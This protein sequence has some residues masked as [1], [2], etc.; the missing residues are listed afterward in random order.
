MRLRVGPTNCSY[1][2][3]MK[4]LALTKPHV[5]VHQKHY[6]DSGCADRDVKFSG[7]IVNVPPTSNYLPQLP[8]EVSARTSEA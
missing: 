7:R 5:V 1:R 6:C 8:T 4:A 2:G 3:C